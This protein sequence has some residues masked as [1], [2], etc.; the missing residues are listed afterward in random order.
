LF[1]RIVLATGRDHARAMTWFDGAV[2][3]APSYVAQAHTTLASTFRAAHDAG[4]SRADSLDPDQEDS[5]YRAQ[6][7]LH[8]I[9]DSDDYD[10]DD[11]ARKAER[12]AARIRDP[13]VRAALASTM[14]LCLARD[15]WD[16]S[17]VLEAIELLT[18]HRN[19]G[20][21][22]WARRRLAA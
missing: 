8:R 10:R 9:F 18:G 2:A 7:R 13:G 6:R 14:A 20:L 19:V 12:L 5:L 21:A 11:A 17:A 15:G 1:E 3:R 4:W 16:E 22:R